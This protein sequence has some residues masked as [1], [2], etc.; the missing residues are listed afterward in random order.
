MVLFAFCYPQGTNVPLTAA[1]RYMMVI[2][3]IIV[4][5]AL[6]GKRPRFDR[7]FLAFSLPLFAVNIVLFISH[8]WVA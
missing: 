8:Y 3:P 6:W 5:F 4:L 1:P 7:L 2:F